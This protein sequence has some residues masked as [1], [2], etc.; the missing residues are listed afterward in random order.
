MRKTIRWQITSAIVALTIAWSGCSK[1]K[2]EASSPATPEPK[3]N[4]SAPPSATTKQPADAAGSACALLTSEEIAAVQ[5]EAFK[6]TKPSEKSGAGLILSQCYFE[7]PTPVNSVVLTVTLKAMNAGGRDP[8]ESW[9]E[10]FHG[11]KANKVE[12]EEEGKEKDKKPEKVEGLGDE[13]FW[14]GSRV[15]GA[16]Y[17]LKGNCYFRISVG[18][19]GDKATKLARSKTLAQS[20][21]KRL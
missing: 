16:L 12:E 4:Q 7:L 1:P 8:S 19:A 2:P 14:T 15:G 18:G 17:V 21:L 5:G 6:D 20:V 9:R 13:A 11:E 3:A 10:I